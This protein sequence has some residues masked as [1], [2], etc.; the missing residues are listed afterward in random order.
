MLIATTSEPSN[1]FYSGSI[2]KG[3]G[4]SDATIILGESDSLQSLR[5]PTIDG[6]PQIGPDNLCVGCEVMD[7]GASPEPGHA[8]YH[9]TFTSGGRAFD[10]YVEFG[11]TPTIGELARVN[12]TLETLRTTPN[13]S[14]AQPAPGGT[15]V[16]S[17][18]DGARPAVT[19]K[20]TDRTLSWSYAGGSSL[21][22][23]AGWTG[24]TYLVSDP[25][26]PINLYGFGS[27]DIP[28]GGYCAPLMALQELPGNGALVWIDRYGANTQPGSAPTA[29]PASPQVGPGTEPAPESTPC[30]AGAAVQS[31]TWS[32]NGHI[33]AVYVTWG[34]NVTPETIAETEGALASF[35]AGS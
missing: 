26:D 3:M 33:Y 30:T 24:W 13:P 4:S 1:P 17:L 34:P 14:P 21:Q 15:A 31:F 10:L 11:A 35:T 16:G 7:G 8:L 12:A 27:W 5:W 9:D 28:Q 18:Y 19:A 20:D 2:L 6:P 23:P 32:L 22:V 25:S 29:W